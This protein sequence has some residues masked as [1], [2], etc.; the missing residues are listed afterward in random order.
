MSVKDDDALDELL[1][2]CQSGEVVRRLLKKHGWK[3]VLNIGRESYFRMTVSRTQDEKTGTDC[4]FLYI[5]FS[6]CKIHMTLK[7]LYY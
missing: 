4:I 5:I 7:E 1:A 6:C 3:S 2:L